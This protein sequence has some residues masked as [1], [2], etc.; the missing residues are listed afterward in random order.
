LGCEIPRPDY[1][2]DKSM[3]PS[4]FRRFCSFPVFATA[5]AV[6]VVVFPTGC[7]SVFVPKHK[8]L[9]DAISAPGVIKPSGKS[10]RLVAK[11]SMVTQASVPVVKAC[12]DAALGTVGMFEPPANAAPDYFIEVSFGRESAPRADASSRETFL[13]MSA[14][15]NPGGSVDRATGP[16]IWDVKV[17][18]LGVAG[19]IETAMPLLSAVAANYVANDTRLESKVEVPQNSPMV[20]AI[21]TAAIRILEGKNTPQT[22]SAAPVGGTA[23]PTGTPAVATPTTPPPQP[24]PGPGT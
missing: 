10:Y 19:S 21:R 6:A 17:A 5:V 18:V 13:Q 7:S 20:E 9:V 4:R 16:E 22:A 2:S 3:M 12:V 15:T 24:A 14:R 8:V 1:L 11:R 23:T